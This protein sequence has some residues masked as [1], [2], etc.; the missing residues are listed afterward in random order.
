MTIQ[1][2]VSHNISY[3][4]SLANVNLQCWDSIYHTIFHPSCKLN[5]HLKHQLDKK[6]K[7]LL[8]YP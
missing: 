7:W 5:N 2:S 6:Q 8:K 1:C 3:S 4:V